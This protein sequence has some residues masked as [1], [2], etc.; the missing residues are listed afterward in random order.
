MDKSGR[1]HV[2]EEI[3]CTVTNDGTN[4]LYVSPVMPWK[5]DAITHVVLFQEMCDLSTITR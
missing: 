2:K 5:V 3:K 4:S 1:Y